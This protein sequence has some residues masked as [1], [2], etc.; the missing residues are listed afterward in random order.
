MHDKDIGTIV[1]EISTSIAHWHVTDLSIARAASSVELQKLL[2]ARGCSCTP[3]TGVTDALQS[4]LRSCSAADRIVVFG[5]FH[6][7]GGVLE[8]WRP[9]NPT[10]RRGRSASP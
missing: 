9:G 4:A 8:E 5:S 10:E 2:Q 3:H 7:V 1:D 6:T